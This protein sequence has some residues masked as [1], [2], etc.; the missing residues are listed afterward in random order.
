[1]N[2]RLFSVI[3]LTLS[4]TLLFAGI[5]SCGGKKG[6]R[7]SPEAEMAREAFKLAEQLRDAYTSKDMA[8]LRMLSTERGY[9][10]LESSMKDFDSVELNFSPRWVD[11]DKDRIRLNVYWDGKWLL[12]GESYHEKGLAVFQL[13][14]VPLKLD[15]ILRANPFAHPEI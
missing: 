11:I 12:R 8:R 9:S 4:L 3:Y 14:G 2:R 5:S 10:S 15:G 1:M 6:V 7:P 13:T